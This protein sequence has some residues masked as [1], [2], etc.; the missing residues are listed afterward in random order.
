M[1]GLLP[2]VFRA[3]KRNRTHRRYECLS[4]GTAVQNYDIS[5]FYVKDHHHIREYH[6]PPMEKTY[7]F[8]DEGDRKH[9]R[10]NSVAGE[11]DAKDGYWSPP[12]AKRPEHLV[13]FRS[14]SLS[15]FSCITGA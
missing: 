12:A 6:T 5:D 4:A 14:R 15:M 10:C 8:Y 13:R 7:G 1:E 9:R 3:I 2:L 11:Y